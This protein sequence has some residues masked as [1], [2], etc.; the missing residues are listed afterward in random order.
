MLAG[1]NERKAKRTTG[2]RFS[3]FLSRNARQ[4]WALLFFVGRRSRAF[5]V[6]AGA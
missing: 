3:V 2:A 4:Y 6:R 1:L 5:P